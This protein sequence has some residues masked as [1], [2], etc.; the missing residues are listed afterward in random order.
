MGWYSMKE[1]MW[2]PVAKQMGMSWKAVEAMHWQLA[3]EGGLETPDFHTIA[4]KETPSTP[5]L[6]RNFEDY[7]THHFNATKPPQLRISIPTQPFAPTQT[8]RLKFFVGEGYGSSTI[9]ISSEEKG[10]ITAEGKRQAKAAGD[11]LRTRSASSRYRKGQTSTTEHANHQNRWS[12]YKY[13]GSGFLPPVSPIRPSIFE[14]PSLTTEGR[15]QAQAAGDRLRLRTNPIRHSRP[16]RGSSSDY[17]INKNRW[18]SYGGARTTRLDERLSDQTQ[19]EFDGKPESKAADKDDSPNHSSLLEVFEA[20]LAKKMSDSEAQQGSEHEAQAQKATNYANV[21]GANA[22]NS[23]VETQ[24]SVPKE[25]TVDDASSHQKHPLLDGLKML[26]DHL[27]SLAVGDQGPSQDLS[28]T[29]AHGVWSA[30]GGIN[31][32]FQTVSS[33]LQEASNLTRQARESTRGVDDNLEAFLDSHVHNV[34]SGLAGLAGRLASFNPGTTGSNAAKDGLA[35]STTETAPVEAQAVH[36]A[37]SHLMTSHVFEQSKVDAPMRRSLSSPDPESS[38]PNAGYVD[39]LRQNHSAQPFD[40]LEN[41][42]STSP[43]P[44]STRFPTLAQFE[45]QDFAPSTQ[46]AV[47]P[48]LDME[49]L[50]P[51][52][53]NAALPYS[54]EATTQD[55]LGSFRAELLE[56]ELKN[57]ERLSR[58]YGEVF[59]QQNPQ[60]EKSRQCRPLSRLPSPQPLPHQDDCASAQ[61]DL[62]GELLSDYEVQ[63]SRL[64]TAYEKRLPM[65]REQR[66]AEQ[67][68][69]PGNQPQNELFAHLPSSPSPPLGHDSAFVRLKDMACQDYETQIRLLEQQNKKRIL[70]MEAIKQDLQE[71]KRS[72]PAPPP[73]P[74]LP[75]PLLKAYSDDT[76]HIAA[77]GNSAATLVKPFDPLEEEPTARPRFARGVR[78]NATVATTPNR[79]STRD[80]RPLSEAFDAGRSYGWGSSMHNPSHGLR[81]IPISAAGGTGQDRQHGA[82]PRRANT[83][84]TQ[85]SQRPSAESEEERKVCECAKQLKD[86]GFGKGHAGSEERLRVYASA[87]G[88][89]LVDAIDMIDEEEKAYREQV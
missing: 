29:I 45:S 38:A 56:L 53:K 63:L 15:R 87:S 5:T 62:Q 35:S 71:K 16:S 13:I 85:A 50:V 59:A 78:R 22:Q 27:Q 9:Q 11:K 66:L 42:G 57:K 58:V 39:R 68:A 52:K 32:L 89:D 34:E 64:E 81:S 82:F 40:L 37:A 73:A 3:K 47:L 74:L 70:G 48:S 76:E 83:L 30:F 4:P 88:G 69:Q 67:S 31:S 26:N 20:E 19:S 54:A 28:N 49:P 14:G 2:T 6:F 44:D 43:A 25:G 10:S 65:A 55:E 61:V 60:T 23:R 51:S 17:A 1:E 72:L 24:A 18:S 36:E 12:G 86:L 84:W 75:P 33:G 79:H 77:G 80:R 7:R 41:S 21:P 46:P 8:S